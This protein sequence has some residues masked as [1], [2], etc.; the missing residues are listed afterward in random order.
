[1]SDHPYAGG[2]TLT[3]GETMDDDPFTDEEYC[4]ECDEYVEPMAG[5]CPIC[6]KEIA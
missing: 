1:M 2:N 3:P 6:K 5:A 4:K